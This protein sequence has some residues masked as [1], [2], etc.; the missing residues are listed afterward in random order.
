MERR[1]AILNHQELFRFPV[2]KLGGAV[3]FRGAKFLEEMYR[4]PEYMSEVD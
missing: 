2:A 1:A 4:Q 3:A